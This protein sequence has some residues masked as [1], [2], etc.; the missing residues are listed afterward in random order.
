MSETNR[1]GTER[2]RV[3]HCKADQTDVYVGRGPRGRDV[4]TTPN[5]GDRGW[6]GNPFSVEDHSK[7][8]CIEKFEKAFTDKLERDEEFREAVAEL[9]GKVLGCWCQRLDDDEPACHA[10]IIA[11]YADR[12]NQS[13]ETDTDHPEGDA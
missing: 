10:E 11:E 2:T 1:D 6:L 12:L 5:P 13:Q 7:E 8:E 3:G 9:S 4:L